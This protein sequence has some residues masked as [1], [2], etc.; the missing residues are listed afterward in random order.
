M[1]CSSC[2]DV[3]VQVLRRVEVTA[4]RRP[5]DL[6]HCRS[7]DLL[8][9]VDPPAGQQEQNPQ[10]APSW[11][12]LA[13]QD[14]F[15]G[16]TGYVDRNLHASE[17]LRLTLAIGRLLGMPV[18]MG[19]DLGC[20]LGMLARLLRDHGHDFWG[21]DGYAAMELI[22]PFCNPPASAPIQ[23]CT[24]FEVIEHVPDTAAFLR[25]EVGEVPLLVFST[26]MRSDGE[27]PPDD[28]WYFAFGNGQHIRFHSRRSFGEAMR[29]AGLDPETLVTVN[30]PRH[31]RALHAVARDGRWRLAF[32]LAAWLA[33][34]KLGW[35][36]LPWLEP[37]QGLRCQIIPDHERA[38]ALKRQRAEEASAAQVP[39]PGQP[40]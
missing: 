30:G 13:Y 6:V 33:N 27:I 31:P 17:L 29:Q 16:D 37:L 18:S 32:R 1:L 19:C 25:E 14:S 9:L 39:V 5:A 12:E 20:G 11:L 28:W 26:L 22:R 8:A 10:E 34:R 15:Y 35:L 38:M 3:D 21:R 2:G 23:C 24:A 7:C 40:V 4:A 36:L